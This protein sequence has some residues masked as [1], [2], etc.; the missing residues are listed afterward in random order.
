MI[1]EDEK[2]ALDDVASSMLQGGLSFIRSAVKHAMK[3]ATDPKFAK[4][5]FRELDQEC[6]KLVPKFR[7][8]EELRREFV[9]K[10]LTDTPPTVLHSAAGQ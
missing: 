4:H 9:K 1:P 5:I 10:P 2:S 8:G 6:H 3:D 7:E